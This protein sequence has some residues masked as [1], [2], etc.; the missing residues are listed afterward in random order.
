MRTESIAVVAWIPSTVLAEG[1][2]AV[3]A[4]LERSLTDAARAAGIEP[5]GTLTVR[6]TTVEEYPHALA[7]RPTD[8]PDALLHL[9]ELLLEE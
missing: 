5:K 9:G 7:G 6:Q 8:D 3:V 1:E 2:D 4:M